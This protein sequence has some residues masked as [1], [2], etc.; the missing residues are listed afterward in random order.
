MRW[1]VTGVC[2]A[3]ADW[4][5]L[6]ILGTQPTR[7]D[8]GV[9]NR[10]PVRRHDPLIASPLS[11]LHHVYRESPSCGDKVM[12][13]KYTYL[14]YTNCS[15]PLA[16]KSFRETCEGGPATCSNSAYMK[17]LPKPVLVVLDWIPLYLLLSDTAFFLRDY[18]RY[19]RSLRPSTCGNLQVVNKYEGGG[20][21]MGG[22]CSRQVVFNPVK[23]VIMFPVVLVALAWVSIFFFFP[24]SSLIGESFCYTFWN[25]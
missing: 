5:W 4:L 23:I 7:G 12:M 20:W 3:N 18:I 1:P 13:T 8:K 10:N 17:Y 25:Q 19:A 16:F 9:E 15:T 11:L 22:D 14:L 24:S 2:A 21:V 6:L